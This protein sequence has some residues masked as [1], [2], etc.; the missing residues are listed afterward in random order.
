ME[1]LRKITLRNLGCDIATIKGLIAQVKEG[2]KVV[3]ARIVG[4]ASGYKT[5]QTDKGEY[6]KLLGE[7]RAVNLQTGESFQSPQAIIPSFI[8]ENFLPALQASGTVEFAVQVDAKAK[9]TAVA[10]Y[11]FTMTPLVESKASDRMTELMA[12]AGKG[13]PAL[14]APAAPPSPAA[15]AAA[16]KKAK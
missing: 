7:F 6:V 13:L 3:L 15:K 2:E 8:A 5:G 16:K 9:A 10:G 12:I 1:V 4:I 11:E 14:P